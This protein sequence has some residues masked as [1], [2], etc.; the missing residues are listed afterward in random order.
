VPPTDATSV[1]EL[2]QV[3]V[4]SNGSMVVVYTRY[5]EGAGGNGNGTTQIMARLYAPSGEPSSPPVAVTPA[6]D[7]YGLADV[8]MD[9]SGGFVVVYRDH[10]AQSLLAQRYDA[11]GQVDGTVLVVDSAVEH[12]CW[13]SVS[14]VGEGSFA[15]AWESEDA[16]TP[17]RDD[18]FARVYDAASTPVTGI[19]QMNA[20]T[21][22][23]H[24]MPTV[25]LFDNGEMLAVWNSSDAT[26][27]EV[28]MRRFDSQ[29]VPESAEV[30]VSGVVAGRRTYYPSLSVA[31]DG[32]A[33][34]VWQSNEVAEGGSESIVAQRVSP[35][36]GLDGSPVVALET[37]SEHIF[38]S[39]VVVLDDGR[40]LVAWGGAERVAEGYPPPVGVGAREFDAQGAPLGDRYVLNHRPDTLG[41]T[42]SLAAHSG[43]FAA[44]WVVWDLYAGR[45]LLYAQRFAG[46]GQPVGLGPW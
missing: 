22:R 36:G 44:T 10:V 43:R 11:A 31:S 3:A 5:R 1:A 19:F 29:G 27:F 25:A 23:H 45:E 9:D 14:M 38:Y 7:Y 20:I 15:V 2:A 42:V 30:S 46:F 13:F 35:A 37:T 21:A 39:E 24:E 6:D 17:G 40:F 41:F 18:V 28:T 33:V 26:S 4:S 8:A 16:S 12:E 34:V 32:G